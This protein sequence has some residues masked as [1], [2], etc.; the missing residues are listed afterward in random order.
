MAEGVSAIAV[1]T[2]AVG[3]VLV[4]SGLRGAS[5]LQTVQELIQGK[6]PSGINKFPIGTP[7]GGTGG[8]GGGGGGSASGSSIVQIAASMKGQPYCFGGGHGGAPCSSSCTDCSS[9]V[10]CVLFKAGVL[11]DVLDTGGLASWGT[12]VA[13]ADRQPG[14]VIVWNG[15]PGGGHTGIIAD[16]TM[17]WNNPCTGCGGVQLQSYN[18]SH[19]SRL[20]V[21]AVIRRAPGAASPTGKVQPAQPAG[22]GKVAVPKL[23]QD[24][25]SGGWVNC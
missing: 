4:W 5:I 3:G 20:M 19:G 9:Y 25:V 10:S 18:P 6:K 17:M 23:C 7:T 14:D 21:S 2:L 22:N 8:G 11:K 15:G 1:G 16:S 24:P 12:G 13:I